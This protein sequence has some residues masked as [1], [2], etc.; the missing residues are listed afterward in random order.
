MRIRVAGL[1]DVGLKRENNQDHLLVDEELALYI[2]ADGMGGHQGGEVASR[3]C[4][5]TIRDY[6][7]AN[8]KEGG[9]DVLD[10]G[11]NESCSAIFK[12]S[13]ENER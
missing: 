5:E 13:R 2:V 8:P 1:T 6:C 4:V 11:I 12:T 7:Q 3:L 10:H 9:R